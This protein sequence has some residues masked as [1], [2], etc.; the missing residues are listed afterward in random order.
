MAALLAALL[1]ASLARVQPIDLTPAPP[2]ADSRTR[3]PLAFVPNRGQVASSE[4]RYFAWG[5]GSSFTFTRDHI[6]IAL[7][8]GDRGHALHL[9]PLGA[10]EHAQLVARAPTGGHAN[11]IAAGERHANIPMYGA[12]AYREL[13]PGIDMVIKGA[14]GRLKYEFRV[15]P[16][17]DPADIRLAYAGASGVSVTDSGALAVGTSLGVLTDTRP[18]TYQRA[19]GREVP[20]Q[21]GFAVEGHRTYGFSLGS[22]DRTRPLVID[23]GLVYSTF[24]GGPA[25]EQPQSITVDRAGAAYVVGNLGTNDPINYPTTPGAFQTGGPPGQH[26]FVTKLSPDGSDLVYS[27][28]IVG[29]SSMDGVAIDEA[30]NAYVTG[31]T[32]QAAF[33]TTAGA[34]D[35]TLAGDDRYVLKLNATGSAL[36]Y[37]TLLGG[38]GREPVDF[39]VGDERIAVDAL[40]QAYVTGTTM[41]TDFPTTPGAHDRVFS[42][43]DDAFVTKLNAAGSDLVYSTY[44]GGNGG[45]PK[46]EIGVDGSGHAVVGGETTSTDLATAGA[47]DTTYGG[48]NADGFV[49]K[50]T[51][52]GSALSYATYIGGSSTELGKGIALDEDGNAYFAGG[53]LSTDFPTTPGAY[54]TTP[55]NHPADAFVTKLRPDGAS[56]AYST[57]VGGDGEDQAEGIDVNDRGEAHITG[58]TYS[59]DFP[60]TP[61]ALDPALD[62][63]DFFDGFFTKLNASGSTLGYSTFIGGT[64]HDRGWDVA[65]VGGRAYITGETNS[66]DLTVT[67]GAFDES[68]NGVMDA[69]VMRF[70]FGAGLPATLHLSPQAATNPVGTEHCLTATSK[71]PLGEPTPNETVRF[72]VSGAVEASGSGTTGASGQTSFCYD[73]PAFPGTDQ[74]GAFVDTNTDGDQDPGEPGALATKD[75]VSPSST[76][77]CQAS[78]TGRIMAA[79]GDRANFN[80]KVKTRTSGTPSGREAYDDRGPAER[81]RMRSTSIDAL[82]CDRRAATI[83][84]RARVDGDEVGFRIDLEDNGPGHRD[85][86]RI[87]LSTGYDSGEQQPTTGNVKVR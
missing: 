64:M 30:G 6:A 78:G 82:L 34:Y 44:L 62:Q 74:I 8:R 19:G 43:F 50:L 15:A 23:P 54:D 58:L 38:S 3:T 31:S 10:S 61:D 42:G 18:R 70:D 29:A 79:N 4:V 25:Y 1:V 35:R 26:S 87:Q 57:V 28:V 48:P 39:H 20:V 21:S 51:A 73:G 11:Y 60:T 32:H 71:D 13:W 80:G 63:T 75:W 83:F 5:A 47:F 22:Y 36:V 12:L 85:R 69:Y 40:G 55:H 81:V 49:A 67:P 16:G 66:A 41:S 68:F 53:T 77:D 86:Y 27:T 59:P 45:E 2:A 33:P 24:L 37:S 65:T 14:G 76:P 52:D 7:T 17:A 46:T 72:S 9:R 56:L 84:G